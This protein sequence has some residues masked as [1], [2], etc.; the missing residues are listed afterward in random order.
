MIYQ[1]PLA[2]LL[3]LE[4]IGLLRA[5]AGEYDRAFSQARLAEVRQLLD[6]E[7]LVSHGGV[8]VNRGDTV[9]G[10]RQWSATYDEPRNGLFDV[11]EPIMHE[12][13]DALAA[14]NA[15]DAACGT[16]RY[17]GYLA[18]A[19]HQVAG[20]GS[21]PEMLD[22]ARARVPQG[23]FLLGDLHQLPLPDD[24]VD[25]VVSGLALAHV[26][27]LEPVMAEFARVLRPGGHLVISDT[28]HERVFRGS[29]VKALGP[30]GE[31]DWWRPIATP[32]ATTCARPFRRGCRFDAARNPR[33]LPG[34]SRHLGLLT[35][36]WRWGVGRSGR[37]R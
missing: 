11:E 29:V 10:Y 30:K 33:D 26:P 24:A 7:A 8:M 25:L 23:E 37:G 32:L 20:V 28:H 13:L 16:G 21:S 15:L 22:R 2:Y 12:I 9:M 5:W 6:N 36:S 18:G 14:G 17:A 1:H 4:G 31:P 35:P 3:G 34:T 19:G 27:A